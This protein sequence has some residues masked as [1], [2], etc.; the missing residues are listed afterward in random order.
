MVLH[1]GS[2]D[3]LL[4][5]QKPRRQKADRLQSRPGALLWNQDLP[6]HGVQARPTV[7]RARPCPGELSASACSA[8]FN[9]QAWGEGPSY[10]QPGLITG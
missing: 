10:R 1:K 7:H 9:L 2:T 6:L 5:K 3:M 8:G 4:Q